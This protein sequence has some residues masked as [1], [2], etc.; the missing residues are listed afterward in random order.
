MALPRQLSAETLLPIL[1]TSARGRR[2]TRRVST[3]HLSWRRTERLE[4][5]VD[6]IE[7][8]TMPRTPGSF[9]AVP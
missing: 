5:T 4:T 7:L 1:C 2:A 3:G 8:S 6:S 9:G